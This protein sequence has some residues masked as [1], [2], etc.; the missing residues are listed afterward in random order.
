MVGADK[1]TLGKLLTIMDNDGHPL[2][3]TIIKQKSL[4]RFR[5]RALPCTTDRL[6]KSFV[7]RA[8]QLYYESIKGKEISN[9]HTLFTLFT[10]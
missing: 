6:R 8:L 7:L 2:Y 3:N 1:R 5:L 10:G 4:I 9:I